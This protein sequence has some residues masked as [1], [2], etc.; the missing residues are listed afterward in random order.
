[1]AEK[2]IETRPRTYA[3]HCDIFEDAGKV[4]LSME[5][6]GVTKD[7]IDIKV[8][9][10]HLIIHGKRATTE[11]SGDYIIREIKSGDYH[12]DFS[13]DDTID[14]NKIDAAVNNGIV[15]VTLGIKESEKPRKITVTAQ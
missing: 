5:M 3:A 14:R 12:N 7:T 8:D 9:G 15:T 13:L 2:T 11:P 6:P 4:M 10:D 1:M